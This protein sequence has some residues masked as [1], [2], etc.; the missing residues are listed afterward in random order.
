MKD[1][2][3]PRPN[4]RPRLEAPETERSVKSKDKPSKSKGKEKATSD[5]QLDE[6]MQV[7]QPRSQKGPSWKDVDTVASTVDHATSSTSSQKANAKAAI[8]ELPDESPA[9]DEAT[10]DMDWLKRHMK[11]SLDIAAGTEKGFEQ[12]D[13]EMDQPA[14]VSTEPLQY[15][16]VLLLTLYTVAVIKAVTTG[17]S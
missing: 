3:A 4:K 7:M 9:V 13:L 14:E 1:A 17:R 5:M 2:P 8:D 15:C 11:S 6:F 12:S 16:I 10:S